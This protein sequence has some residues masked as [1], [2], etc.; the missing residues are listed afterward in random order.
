MLLDE[1]S[2]LD[3]VVSPKNLSDNDILVGVV[4]PK[5]FDELSKLFGVVSPK[6]FDELS[7]LDGVTPC[8]GVVLFDF[9]HSECSLK[10]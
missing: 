3:G 10:I 7:N 1:L 6:K 5:L 4:S 9:G 2:N 8:F